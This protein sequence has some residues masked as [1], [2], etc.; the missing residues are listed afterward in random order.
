MVKLRISGWGGYLDY[1]NGPNV[2]TRGLQRCKK[3]QLK[4]K[5]EN[6]TVIGNKA[7]GPEFDVTGVHRRRGEAPRGDTI[8]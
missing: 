7:E 4:G 6:V 8:R 5:P 2:I 1:P 3:S